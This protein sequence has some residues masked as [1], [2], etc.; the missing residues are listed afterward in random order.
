MSV[1]P[2]AHVEASQRLIRLP[3]GRTL[4]VGA[5]LVVLAAI[6]FVIIP[7]IL[8][9]AVPH[10]HGVAYNKPYP[11]VPDFELPQA[12]GGTF[13]PADYRGRIVL[14]YFGYTSCPDICPTTLLD[15]RNAMARLG[16]QADDVQVVFVTIDPEND[17]P[18]KIRQYLAAFDRR[19]IGL[20][21]TMEEI[22]P[23][24]DAFHVVV[25]RA[26]D[27]ETV[28]GVTITHSNTMYV[29]DR[30]GH[31]RLM[32]SHGSEPEFVAKDLRILLRQRN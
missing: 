3:G 24:M 16:E 20:Y 8:T 31:L 26:A 6:I 9:V 27:G 2:S 4:P 10:F 28:A 23:V 30:S 1:T 7:G 22:Q 21:G 15:L 5:V 14:Y 11:A 18:D 32:I 13:R 29:A 19:F 12:G 25:R 17:T